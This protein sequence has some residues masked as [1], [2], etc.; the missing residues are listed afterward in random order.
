MQLRSIVRT[1]LCLFMCCLSGCIKKNSP[2]DQEKPVD[3]LLS[4][5]PET[6]DPRYATSLVA[7]NLSR[8]LYASLF[9]F[10]DD[11]NPVPFLAKGVKSISDLVHIVE[12]RNDIYF[13]NG[14]RITAEDVAYTFGALA[15]DD[16]ASPHAS[17]L[18]YIDA[19]VAIDD[20]HVEFKLK[21]AYAPFKVDLASLPIV[22][23]DLCEGK[24]KDCRHAHIGSGPFRLLSHDTAKEVYVFEAFPQWF[25]GKPP[26]KHLRFRV[27]RDATTALLELI[28]G[29][30]DMATM[31]IS[32]F[33]AQTLKKYPHLL[34]VNKYPSLSYSYI[35]MNLR[36]CDPEKTK[37]AEK[38]RTMRALASD[39]VRKAL[40]LALDLDSIVRA[41]FKG[42]A[43]RA[44]AML[45]DGHWAKPADLKPLPYAPAEA[46]RLLDE[47]G[48]K[49]R[50]DKLGRFSITL[51]ATPD[52]FRQSIILLYKHYFEKIGIRASIR[53]KAWSALFEDIKQ[54][55]FEMFSGTWVP[56]LEPDHYYWVFHTDNIP[57]PGRGGGNR[58]AFKDADMDRW[59]MAA[60]HAQDQESRKALYRDIEHRMALLMPYIPLWYEERSVITNKRIQGY[61]QDRTGFFSG[62]RKAFVQ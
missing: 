60:R 10:G 32:A 19:V 50:G 3:M 31:D 2:I 47:A 12:L 33:H 57:G 58:G 42:G 6:L 62:L 9:E 18:D 38:C 16:V 4:S 61:V 37:D 52:R 55:D 27:V 7:T 20:T 43:V 28:N 25:E 14:K 51:L 59:I 46:K 13:H 56:V 39:K 36:G 40:G 11:L 21:R 53:I 5:V 54:G 49:N 22:S 23:K 26:I 35:A 41:K 1:S 45:P 24:S 34:T 8:I 48:Y 30:A 15:T 17:K 29:K 44:T